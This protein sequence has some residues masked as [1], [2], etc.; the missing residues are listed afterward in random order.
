VP[1]SPQRRQALYAYLAALMEDRTL[2]P[3][4]SGAETTLVVGKAIISDL[5]EMSGEVAT[6][7]AASFFERLAQ[8][9][10]GK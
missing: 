8:T 2:R 5:G 7:R 4:L 10:R 3:G 9:L 6:D 1:L